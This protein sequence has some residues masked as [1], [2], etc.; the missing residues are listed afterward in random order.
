MQL[1][2]YTNGDVGEAMQWMNELDKEYELTNDE[3]G[4][5]DFIDELKEKGYITENKQ[6]GRNKNHTK[7][8]TGHP[9]KKPGRNFRQTKK[10]KTGRSSYVSN[11]DR[12]MK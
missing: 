6:N 7:N 12:V 11:R 4:M 3:Y 1:L 2:T 8:R 9:Q 5:G 10:N